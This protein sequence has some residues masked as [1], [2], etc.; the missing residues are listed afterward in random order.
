L[1]LT[2]HAEELLSIAT[3]HEMPLFQ[4]GAG[5]FFGFTEAASGQTEQGIM[6]MHKAF[7]LGVVPLMFVSLAEAQRK[8]GRPELGLSAVKEGLVLAE[9]T[10]QLF[11]QS[12]LYR[13]KAELE[14]LHRT[15]S[16]ETEAERGFRTAIEVARDQNAKWWELRATNS[17]ARL[18]MRQG[19]TEEARTMLAEIY[20]WFTEGFEFPDL[21]DAK[22][23]LDELGA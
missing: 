22:A 17:L 21:K 23:L 20:N 11:G 3:E 15:T 16:G 6:R 12:E 1:T 9:Q 19:K 5:F 2:A 8:S 13:V 4:A 10:G 18:L 14:L 7:G